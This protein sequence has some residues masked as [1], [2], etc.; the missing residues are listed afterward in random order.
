MKRA[1]VSRGW[2]LGQCDP[3]LAQR[4]PS[5]RRARYKRLRRVQNGRQ[6]DPPSA[7]RWKV[8]RDGIARQR[9]PRAGQSAR[10]WIAWSHSV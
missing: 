1:P 10:R 5:P 6:S 7:V 9:L 3:A 2:R 8:R 4:P